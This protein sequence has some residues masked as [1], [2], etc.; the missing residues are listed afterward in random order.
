MRNMETEAELSHPHQS[1]LQNQFILVRKSD[2]GLC[3]LQLIHPQ[4]SG[5][6]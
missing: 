3:S 4:L 5:S 2:E 1:P 6:S